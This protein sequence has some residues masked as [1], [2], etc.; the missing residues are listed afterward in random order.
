MNAL[1][2]EDDPATQLILQRILA[3]RGYTVTVAP[4]AEAAMDHVGR[5]FFP[6]IVLDVMLPGMNGIEF[7]RWLRTRP[8]A[9][10]QYVLAG[11]GTS[12]SSALQELLD[13]G[14]NDYLAK[15]YSPSLL[16]IRL[17]IAEKQIHV[18][19][20][21]KELED[22]LLSLARTDPLTGLTNRAHLD[23]LLDALVAQASPTSPS[24]LLYIDLDNF[25]IVNDT[26]GHAAGD[27]LLVTIAAE[28]QRAVRARDTV[29]RFGGDEFIVILENTPFSAASQMAN[30]IRDI[31]DHL[32]FREDERTFPVGGSIGLVAIDGQLDTKTVIAAADT[33]CY[34]A[35][36]KGRNRVEIGRGDDLDVEPLR[37]DAHWRTR[38]RDGLHHNQFF[39]EA[40]PIAEIATGRIAFHEAL[41]RLAQPPSEPAPPDLFLP[42]AR[43]FQLMTDIDQRVVRLTLSYLRQSGSSDLSVN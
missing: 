27:R 14:A 7:C 32:V 43:R 41:L 6:L 9:P 39:L 40:Q 38:I 10:R 23:Q 4:T 30:R 34:R 36:A 17:A 24:A 19:H 31:L 42:A 22:R 16:R 13:A 35:K 3:A 8:E 26:L 28:L 33:A 29:V 1:I 15:P 18:L 20:Q 12:S 37:N 25:K 21:R 2:V 5:T 11:T